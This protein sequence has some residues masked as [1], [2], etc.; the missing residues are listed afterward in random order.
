[1]RYVLEHLLYRKKPIRSKSHALILA[2]ICLI[3]LAS[4]QCSRSE[5]RA[6]S[7]E[8]TITVLH[9]CDERVL[10]PYWRYT[11]QFLVFLPLVARNAKGELEA[12]LAK[13]W[14]HSADYGTWTIH[15][16]T[17][18]FWQDGV[19]VTAHDIKF[20]MDLLSHP[21][22]LAEPPSAYSINV[23]DDS[24]YTI[25]FHKQTRYRPL[26]DYQV[27]YPKHLLE[28]LDPAEI[29]EWDFWIHP[30]GNGPYRY[31]RHVPQTMIELEA[32][33]DFYKGKPKIDR[34]VLKFRPSGDPSLTEL[35]SGNVDMLLYINRMDLLTLSKD[36]HFRV[37]DRILHH[38]LRAIAWNQHHPF[39]R[40]PKV[41]RALTLAI[42]R[43]EL[44]QV[45]Y[46]PEGTPLF[47]VIFTKEQLEGGVLP[48][49]LPYDPKRANQL[50]DEAGWR[51]VDGDGVRERDGEPFRF[52]ALVAH[53]QGLDAA[54]VYIQAQLRR[55]GV[56]MDVQVLDEDSAD[57]RIWAGEFEA[58]IFIF[59]NENVFY[60]SRFFG[61][62]SPI[63]YS[64][65]RV[66][67]LLRAAEATWNPNEVDRAYRDLWPIFREDLPVTFLSPVVW[68]GVAHR[69]IQ[70]LSSPWRTDPVRNM[71]DLWLEDDDP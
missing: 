35:L 34:V 14:E 12:R 61:D 43:R 2:C 29:W 23:L 20:T 71:D 46:L 7:R 16:R 32:N 63:A 59:Y 33:P 60:H 47:D 52:T 22:V 53:T 30:V 26:D 25:T 1:M 45:L 9:C 24:T 5:D 28:D 39:F 27:Y 13:S 6:Y 8:S 51:D 4:A 18:V 38:R 19:R 65:P 11:P 50:L 17:N 40:D 70:G 44:L 37:Y 48:E 54:A 49:P 56:E 21:E 42:N 64:R 55:V 10:G 36:H 67:A 58:A 62:D 15:L 41:R 68:T 66:S 69:R 3:A 31:V 57:E